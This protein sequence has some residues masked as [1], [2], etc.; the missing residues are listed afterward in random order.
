MTVKV[1]KDGYEAM[2]YIFREGEYS[3]C[4]MCEHPTLILLDL[5][6]PKISGIEILKRIRED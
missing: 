1:L 4:G 3:D 2:N 6:L 5:N